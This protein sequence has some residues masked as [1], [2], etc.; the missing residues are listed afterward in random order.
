MILAGIDY[1]AG[2]IK[3]VLL[4]YLAHGSKVLVRESVGGIA[5]DQ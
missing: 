1:T 5:M 3:Q 4:S 2:R